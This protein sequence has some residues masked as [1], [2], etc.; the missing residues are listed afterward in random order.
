MSLGDDQSALSRVFDVLGIVSALGLFGLFVVG[1]WA[2]SIIE[3]AG[4]EI[5]APWFHPNLTGAIIS[6]IDGFDRPLGE[7]SG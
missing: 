6:T 5:K 7:A 2:T 1:Y 3:F 4:G